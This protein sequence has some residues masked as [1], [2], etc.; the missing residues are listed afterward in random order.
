MRRK[1][2]VA[3]RVI[4]GNDRKFRASRRRGVTETW[5]CTR[6]H[7]AAQSRDEKSP[8]VSTRRVIHSSRLGR[9]NRSTFIRMGRRISSG[10]NASH[11]GPKRP[12]SYI[13]EAALKI[14]ISSH[15]FLPS[16]GGLENASMMLAEQ[17]T[18]E[19]NE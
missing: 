19:S 6:E 9:L 10:R 14:L 15:V 18:R 11:S 4:D 3:R 8:L 13:T 12:W 1:L 5:V 16:V 7:D 17:F 2:L